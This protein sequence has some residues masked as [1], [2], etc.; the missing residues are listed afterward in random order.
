MKVSLPLFPP[1]VLDSFC[2]SLR[3]G[4]EGDLCLRIEVWACRLTD[5]GPEVP[6]SLRCLGFCLCTIK[7]V[8]DQGRQR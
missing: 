5:E 8:M 2:I 4:S 3:K 7:G 6:R 1:V